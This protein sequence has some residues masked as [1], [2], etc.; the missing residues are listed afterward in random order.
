MRE[1]LL[2]EIPSFKEL[3][4]FGVL[5]VQ[6]YRAQRIFTLMY[7]FIVADRLKAVWNNGL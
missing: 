1:Q 5:A 7:K 3:P 2:V 4:R 6:G